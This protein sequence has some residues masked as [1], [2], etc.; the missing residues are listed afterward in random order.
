MT[1]IGARYI[2]WAPFHETDPEQDNAYPRYGTPDQLA[3]LCAV[4]DTPNYAE[5]KLYGDGDVVEYVKEFVDADLNVE[6]TSLTGTQGKNLLGLESLDTDDVGYG[7]DNAP[8]GGLAFVTCEIRR[9]SKKYNAVYYPKVKFS[10]TGMEY[11]TKNDTITF[12]TGKLTGKAFGCKKVAGKSIWKVE[13]QESFT[14]LDDAEAWV[15]AK[16]AAYTVNP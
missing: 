9:G 11:N 6:V 15:D 14:D 2:K 13:P 4:S 3:E 16:I 12:A 1:R 10:A 5:A 8:Y 7:E